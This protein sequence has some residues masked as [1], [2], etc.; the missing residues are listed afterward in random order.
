MPSWLLGHVFI[1][2]LITVCD[3]ADR[4]CP[5]IWPQ[6]GQRIFWPVDDPACVEGTEEERLA[7]F[8]VARDHM[9]SRIEDW[10]REKG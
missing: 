4:D 10:L 3:H 6:G 8:R 5:R 7:A 9:R 1:R 2:Y